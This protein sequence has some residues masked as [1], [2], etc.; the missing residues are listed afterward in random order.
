MKSRLLIPAAALLALFTACKSPSSDVPCRC[1]TP[2]ADIEGCPNPDC[3]S[4]KGNSENPHCVCGGIE[5]PA[6]KN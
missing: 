5:I 4:G 1:G 6:K 2:I 3:V